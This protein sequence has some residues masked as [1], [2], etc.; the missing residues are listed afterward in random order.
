MPPHLQVHPTLIVGRFADHTQLH[1]KAACPVTIWPSA[2]VA[3]MVT[4][5]GT[6][7][8]QVAVTVAPWEGENWTDGSLAVQ[9]AF[10]RAAVTAGQPGLFLN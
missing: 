3:V 8:V 10:T 6:A 7:A 4:W 1:V 5:L 2:E 9:L